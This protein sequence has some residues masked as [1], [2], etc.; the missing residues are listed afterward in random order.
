LSA[1]SDQDPMSLAAAKEIHA[2]A[3]NPANR[4]MTFADQGHG[5]GLIERNPALEPV[6][7]EWLK[8]PV[9]ASKDSPARANNRR[10]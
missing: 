2:L 9:G 7:I 1:V 10:K 8:S 4:L 5:F 3:R 6:V